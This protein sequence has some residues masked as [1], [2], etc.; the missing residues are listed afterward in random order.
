MAKGEAKKTNK[1]IDQERDTANK[2][3]GGISDQLYSRLPGAQGRADKTFDSAYGGYND[4]LGRARGGGFG[5]GSGGNYD[6][7][8]NRFKG[9]GDTG[10]VDDEGKAR[11]RGNGVFDEFARTGGVSDADKT[12]LRARGTATIPAF[13]DSIKR[14]LETQKAAQGG[15]NPGYTAQMEELARNESR[16]AQDAAL[17]AETGILD[18]VNEGRKWGS[19]S[20]SGAEQGLQE[21]LSRNKLS[22]WQG[23]MGARQA[24]NDEDYRGRALGLQ[25]ELGALEGLRGLRTDQP[26]EEF[27]LYDRLLGAAGGRS[28]ATEQNLGLRAQYNPNRDFMDRLSQIG[29]AAGGLMGAFGGLGGSRQ[30]PGNTGFAGKLPPQRNVWDEFYGGR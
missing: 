24:G 29:G 18:R 16:G 17:N 8:Y 6:E 23:A 27:G 15:Y 25:G 19:S 22:G 5:G 11:I 13:Y 26:G 9:F 10:G 14:N 20:L 2:E 1:Y 4:L 12:N 21:L 28:G 3:Y 7:L 30:A